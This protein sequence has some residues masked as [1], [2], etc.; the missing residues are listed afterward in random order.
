MMLEIASIG[1]ISAEIWPFEPPSL[2]SRL[3]ESELKISSK[4]FTETAFCGP[5]DQEFLEGYGVESASEDILR[6]FPSQ[7]S[8]IMGKTEKF[9]PPAR[10]VVS[11]STQMA[12]ISE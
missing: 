11:L 10:L 5:L 7:A 2:T 1:L 4:P 3:I 6:G 8:E 12:Y 9:P